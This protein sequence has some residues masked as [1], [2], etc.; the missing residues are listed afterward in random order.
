MN[1]M[2]LNS[3]SL[4]HISSVIPLFWLSFCSAGTQTQIKI[5]S[6]S[7]PVYKK[8]CRHEVTLKSETFRI[9]CRRLMFGSTLGP[10]LFNLYMLPLG[11]VGDMASGDEQD[12]VGLSNLLENRFKTDLKLCVGSLLNMYVRQKPKVCMRQKIIR[13]I[14]PCIRTPVCHFPFINHRVPRSVRTGVGCISCPVH[15]LFSPSVP[16]GVI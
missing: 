9:Q 10:M 6:A 7:S 14:K 4:Q 8:Y 5:K 1:H 13:F 16:S 15:T 2:V 11:N 12:E 3:S